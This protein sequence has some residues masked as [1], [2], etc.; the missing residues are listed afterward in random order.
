MIDCNL[1]ANVHTDNLWEPGWV[2]YFTHGYEKWILIYTFYV[3]S[4]FG[5]WVDILSLSI[6]MKIPQAQG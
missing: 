5:F 1:C 6:E 3:I 2:T 4:F